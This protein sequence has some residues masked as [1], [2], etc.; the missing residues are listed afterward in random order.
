IGDVLRADDVEPLGAD[1]AQIWRVLFCLELVR[2]FFRNEHFLGHE[3]LHEIGGRLPA[4][5]NIDLAAAAA[6]S[7]R[8][9]RNGAD[10]AMTF[11]EATS[12]RAASKM[13]TIA[14]VCPFD[15]L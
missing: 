6:W 7:Q 5:C 8:F 10:R 13:A 15:P 9:G 2:H 1:E 12:A 11:D 4:H 3:F 14:G